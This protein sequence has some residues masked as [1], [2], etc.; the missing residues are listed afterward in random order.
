MD[1]RSTFYSIL[2]SVRKTEFKFVHFADRRC[3]YKLTDFTLALSGNGCLN[4]I[5]WNPMLF[6]YKRSAMIS[7]HR[8]SKATDNR[9]L[10]C[11]SPNSV[12]TAATNADES[13]PVRHEIGEPN[14]NPASRSNLEAPGNPADASRC[15]ASI[16]RGAKVGGV[17]LSASRKR[18]E[19]RKHLPTSLSRAPLVTL[20]RE[21][22]VSLRRLDDGTPGSRWL[23]NLSD[24]NSFVTHADATPT[25][26]ETG[27]L[28][29]GRRVCIPN[30]SLRTPLLSRGVFVRRSSRP[31]T[32]EPSPARPS[33]WPA[34]GAASR[35]LA[36]LN[37]LNVVGV[38]AAPCALARSFAINSAA[39]R[40]SHTRLYSLRSLFLYFPYFAPGFEKNAS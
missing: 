27:S 12:P 26:S 33:H 14:D 11:Y 34:G 39:A 31:R 32:A 20:S 3:D 7:C 16:N 38:R 36:R 40:A 30:R 23:A 9:R 1:N 17:S 2:H 25:R 37:R 8:H 4:R 15:V 21:G 29:P 18:A 35:P 13:R 6:N 19:W 5:K 22:T 24:V 10:R 28:Q